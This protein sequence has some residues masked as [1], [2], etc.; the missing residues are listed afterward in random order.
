M[1]TSDLLSAEERELARLLGRPGSAAG[2]SA[3]VDAAILAMARNPAAPLEVAAAPVA[4]P[5][6]VITALP[7]RTVA[8]GWGR[9]RRVVSSLA[10]VASLVLVVGLA[11]QLRPLPPQPGMP[12][13]AAAEVSAAPAAASAP[14]DATGVPMEAA[15]SNANSA[16]SAAADRVADAEPAPARALAP[17]TPV[18]MP[19]AAPVAE[20]APAAPVADAVSAPQAFRSAAVAAPAPPAPPAPA[21]MDMQAEPASADLQRTAQGL[22]P[23]QE[24]SMQERPLPSRPAPIPHAGPKAMAKVAEARREQAQAADIGND[25]SLTRQQWLKRIRERRDNGDLEGARASIH[26]FILDYPEARIPRDL[27]PLLEP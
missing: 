1:N 10:A 26:Q 5:G 11:W 15:D 6:P 14:A 9:R 13:P 24:K 19:S 8:S 16:M 21:A 22:A 3:G 4:A 20:V 18:Q 7:P 12:L 2:P 27:R 23:A 17:T 25:A